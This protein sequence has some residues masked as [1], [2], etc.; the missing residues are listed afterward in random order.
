MA[1]RWSFPLALSDASN[2]H[3][4][5]PNRVSLLG[6]SVGASA[7]RVSPSRV[8]PNRM[9]PTMQDTFLV[10]HSPPVTP[11]ERDSSAQSP[12][13]H[14]STHSFLLHQNKTNHQPIS[15]LQ[16]PL[17]RASPYFS[18]E[19]RASTTTT[20]AAAAAAALASSPA[21]QF[22]FHRP[23]ALSGPS[24]P[25]PPTPH[26]SP[27]TTTTTTTYP[28]VAALVH[29]SKMS[30]SISSIPQSTPSESLHQI[31]QLLPSGQP[32]FRLHTIQP[33][34]ALDVIEQSISTTGTITTATTTSSNSATDH[35]I[36][37]KKVPVLPNSS[38]TPLS[39]SSSD[40][41]PSDPCISSR[42]DTLNTSIPGH[43]TIE[44]TPPSFVAVV[45]GTQEGVESLPSSSLYRTLGNAIPQSIS[46]SST[47]F[48]RPAAAP[49][50]HLQIS[51]FRAPATSLACPTTGTP[52]TKTTLSI[53]DGF[54]KPATPSIQR[55]NIGE[56]MH[57][58]P[59]LAQVN[60]LSSSEKKMESSAALLD[61]RHSPQGGTRQPAPIFKKTI[62][63]AGLVQCSPF[64]R[65]L[66][67][68]IGRQHPSI[69]QTDHHDDLNGG[70]PNPSQ[71]V[72]DMTKS[73][74]FRDTNSHNECNEIITLAQNMQR[75]YRALQY[76]MTAANADRDKAIRVASE[77]RTT[78]LKLSKEVAAVC[79]VSN[80]QQES[81]Q[82]AQQRHEKMEK[83]IMMYRAA[84]HKLHDK[85]NSLLLS[86]KEYIEKLAAHE[87]EMELFQSSKKQ[88]QAELDEIRLKAEASTA[89]LTLQI[90]TL[91]SQREGLIADIQRAN[92]GQADANDALTTAQ[93]KFDKE[94]T[95][96][97]DQL[98]RASTKASQATHDLESYKRMMD[99]QKA[100]FDIECS[101]AKIALEEITLEM[102]SWRTK[103]VDTD[104]QCDVL[105]QTLL[106]LQHGLSE[107]Q[108]EYDTTVTHLKSLQLKGETK[109]HDMQD[110][111][112]A[113][114]KDISML[115]LE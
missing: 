104:T 82:F 30:S 80:Y 78:L 69:V 8:S 112:D 81:I 23:T 10:G 15:P 109:V 18:F 44:S 13:L 43:A 97:Q 77:Q 62:E 48:T 38:L 9:S 5:K 59:K 58:D 11:M 86:T 107:K 115:K 40:T 108:A 19:P 41:I 35:E 98:S 57:L 73:F 46:T 106:Q 102:S 20:A 17:R 63:P 111:V 7:T 16:P 54:A 70:M 39:D 24:T 14:P 96:F 65:Q 34:S 100:N 83:T 29:S 75:L 113:L 4:G 49:M 2:H 47:P 45:T 33:P 37:P 53:I 91:V 55:P 27:I 32:R 90:N 61:H 56:A 103:A 42:T 67:A 110:L 3:G 52:T 74:G 64:Q 72:I 99:V 101:Q 6:E 1:D 50:K 28:V 93:Q 105:R 76:D 22:K 89:A 79:A 84:I 66:R 87:K 114:N 88:K 71:G 92:K 36:Q 31:Q 12:S 25:N 85:E 21:M 94:S 68:G 51:R 60:S 95:D 26:L